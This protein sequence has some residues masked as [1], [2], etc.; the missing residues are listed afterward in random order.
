MFD[1]RRI[2]GIIAISLVF[3]ALAGAN[4]SAAEAVEAEGA[5]A[6]ENETVITQAGSFLI[7]TDMAGS[8]KY[9]EGHLYIYG[10]TVCV[11]NSPEV[12]IAAESIK[13][14]G[15]A[16]VI[17]SGVNI[18]AAESAAVTVIP[19]ADAEIFLESAD[20][21]SEETKEAQ[22]ED[23]EEV[24][25]GVIENY[26]CGA[27]GF[28]GIEAGTLPGGNEMPALYSSIRITG[29]G[30]LTCMGGSGAAGIG[31]S[32]GQYACGI[33]S[34]ESGHVTAIAGEKAD[35]IGCGAENT[36]GIAYLPQIS[37]NVASL[38]AFADGEGTA[39]AYKSAQTDESGDYPE[40]YAQA[41]ILR[42]TFARSSDDS[43]SGLA[44]VRVKATTGTDEIELDMPEGY[45]DF[46]VKTAESADYM[47]EQ[48]GHVW[49]GTSEE[50]YSG[51]LTD[52]KDVSILF[53]PGKKTVK[54]SVYL[55][56]LQNT[57]SI[58][59][60][61]IGR[62]DDEDDKDGSRPDSVTVTLYANG[63]ETGRTVTLSEDNDWQGT[64]DD[65]AV[66]SDSVRQSY[67][68]VE[69]KV[70][71]YMAAVCGS[72]E[73]GYTIT[74]IHKPMP[75]GRASDEEIAKKPE[76]PLKKGTI[77]A[78]V[79]TTKVSK[80]MPVR[81]STTIKKTQSAKTADNS[82][83]I[84]WGIMLLTAVAVLFIWMRIE[85]KRE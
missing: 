53:A 69:E 29:D 24:P 27:E 49:A 52:D 64:F 82:N 46:A 71:G 78:T 18:E 39:V 30:Y 66:Y 79:V 13:I 68:V 14:S 28:A 44:G 75:E 81:T 5:E 7:E 35:G 21:V 56:P 51:E 55:V 60:D 40:E 26:L 63:N 45:R 58:N 32:R 72:D 83:T 80:S 77:V 36:E 6:S 47:I 1:I 9:E 37:E 76:G 50:N 61:V 10:G 48:G 38:L 74:N 65:L 54:E 59:I 85:Q 4:V 62:W 17:F 25:A 43:L 31:G 84:I 73:E 23:G 19:G 11:K 2:T 16:K 34:I 12:R 67:S 41:L 20:D 70:G 33:I 15:N 57:P 42:G 22:A 8:F 3:F